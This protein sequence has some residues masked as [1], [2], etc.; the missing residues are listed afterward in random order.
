VKY[1]HWDITGAIADFN[2]AIEINADAWFPYG[3][4]GDAKYYLGDKS[5]AC[6]DWRKAGELEYENAYEA[7]KKY[8]R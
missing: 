5:G 7:I 6:L 2:K 3:E 1:E 8:C 4:R